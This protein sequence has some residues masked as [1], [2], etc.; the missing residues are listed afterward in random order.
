MKHL[1]C[2][3]DLSSDEIWRILHMARDLKKEWKMEDYANLV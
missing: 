3:A 1:V 2:L